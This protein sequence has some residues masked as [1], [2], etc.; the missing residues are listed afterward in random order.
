MIDADV[1]PGFHGTWSCPAIIDMLTPSKFAC[2][3]YMPKPSTSAGGNSGINF[4]FAPDL[5]GTFT[6]PAYTAHIYHGNQN[7]YMNSI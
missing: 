3:R 7:N 1:V 5:K 4:R 6:A 2:G